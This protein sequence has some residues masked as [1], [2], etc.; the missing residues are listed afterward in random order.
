MGRD[1]PQ[2]QSIKLEVPPDALGTLHVAASLN[3]RKFD[4]YLL[5]FAFGE[6]VKL[7]SPVTT[8]STADCTISVLPARSGE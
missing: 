6:N 7:T 5:N 1:L 2:D 3:Y 8:M 4:Q